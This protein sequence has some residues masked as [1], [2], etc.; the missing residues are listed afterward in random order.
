MIDE[1]LL[2]GKGWPQ[3]LHAVQDG[4]ITH[5]PSAFPCN[6]LDYN[7]V[8]LS[9]VLVSLFSM[10][11]WRHHC[12]HQENIISPRAPSYMSIKSPQLFPS[13]E[14]LF[15]DHVSYHFFSFSYDILQGQCCTGIS[16]KFKHFTLDG[17]LSR[18]RK[19]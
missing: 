9:L 6:C 15:T 4:H 7:H 19:I 16:S 11:K 14:N 17:S 1:I 3:T 18:L 12:D 2:C 13:F 8:S 10:K 5:D